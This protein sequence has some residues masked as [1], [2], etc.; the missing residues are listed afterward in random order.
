MHTLATARAT[1]LQPQTYDRGRHFPNLRDPSIAKKKLGEGARTAVGFR[2]SRVNLTYGHS[3][4]D[5]WTAPS[6]PLSVG[7]LADRLAGHAR[8]GRDLPLSLEPPPPPSL[9]L[10]LLLSLALSLSLYIY[11]CTIRTMARATASRGSLKRESIMP[12]VCARLP[13]AYETSF[14]YSS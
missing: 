10:S 12:T 14:S 11:I 1:Q 5:S 7:H 4:R 3:W 13:T 6:R 8:P 9:P 2:I